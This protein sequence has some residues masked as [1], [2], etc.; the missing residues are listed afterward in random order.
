MG[1]TTGR[2]AKYGAGEIDGI[3]VSA[4]SQNAVVS[5]YDGL[6]SGGT[7]IWSSG[8]LGAQTLP[9]DID[10]KNAPF[11]TGLTLV[12]SGANASVFLVYE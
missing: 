9:F 12:I 5:I 10:M 7:L 8:V 3:V 6:T 1:T 11:A 2:V 4:V